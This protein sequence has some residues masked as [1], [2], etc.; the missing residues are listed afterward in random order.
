MKYKVEN[1]KIVRNAYASYRMS[2]K[3]RLHEVY[4]SWSDEKEKAWNECYKEC[5]ENNGKN[6]RII[7]YG[8]WF[9]SCGYV[10]EC[11]GKEYFRYHTAY[12]ARTME[13][14]H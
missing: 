8:T 14:K 5:E 4:G 6:F 7:S 10:F 1:T 3:V 11:E 12:N 2:D 13:I 9:F